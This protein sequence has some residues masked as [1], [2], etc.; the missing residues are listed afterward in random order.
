MASKFRLWTVLWLLV[1]LGS[2]SRAWGGEPYN[3]SPF[4][5]PQGA[6]SAEFIE[7]RNHVTVMRFSGNY[8]KKLPTGQANAAAR[9]VVAREFFRPH[10]DNYD[11]LVIFTG[12]EFD[13]GYVVPY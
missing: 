13:T 5:I 10:P 12:F 6:Y 3:P 4:D 9:A 7:D 11:F 2:V 8:D 1:L